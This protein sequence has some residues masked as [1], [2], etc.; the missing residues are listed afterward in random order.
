M[1]SLETLAVGGG[2][3]EEGALRERESRKPLHGGGVATR[4]RAA[5]WEVDTPGGGKAPQTATIRQGAQSPSLRSEAG[6]GGWKPCGGAVQEGELEG[7]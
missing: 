7:A 6:A 3:S 5:L 1:R 4:K 2:A